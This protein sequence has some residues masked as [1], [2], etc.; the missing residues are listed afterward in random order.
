MTFRIELTGG[1]SSF[2]DDE[3]VRS[4][5]ADMFAN[6][7]SD[8]NPPPITRGLEPEESAAAYTFGCATGGVGRETSLD[9]LIVGVEFWRTSRCL[10]S[11]SS[12]LASSS[13]K[14]SARSGSTVLRRVGEEAREWNE[15]GGELGMGLGPNKV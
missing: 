6:T 4:G 2:S 14:A 13:S 12:S 9:E 1:N 7:P 11:V 5:R 10:S 8:P 15:G 3:S